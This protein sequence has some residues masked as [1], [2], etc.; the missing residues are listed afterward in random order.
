MGFTESSASFLIVI[1]LKIIPA[2]FFHIFQS[3]VKAKAHD[4]FQKIIR[5]FR[6]CFCTPFEKAITWDQIFFLLK[7]R[8]KYQIF[9]RNSLNTAIVHYYLKMRCPY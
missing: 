5:L 2:S 1:K 3:P 4:S 7:K 8:L 6:R 9:V